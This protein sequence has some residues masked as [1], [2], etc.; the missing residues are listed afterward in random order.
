[1]AIASIKAAAISMAV[2]TLEADSGLRPIDSMALA[3]TLPMLKAGII[4]PTAIVKAMAISL[5]E[6][7]LEATMFASAD[8][9]V[10]N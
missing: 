9:R 6:S 8:I 5:M 4:P 1:M 2:I 7:R 10:I 3:P